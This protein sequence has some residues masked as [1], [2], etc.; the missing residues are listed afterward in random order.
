MKR[1]LAAAVLTAT[2]LIGGQ[3]WAQAAC[4]TAACYYMRAKSYYH[5]GR[6]DRAIQDL[7]EAIHLKPDYAE[8][9]VGR[10]YLFDKK[11][12]KDRAIQDYSEA[13]RLKPDYAMAYNNRGNI[14]ERTGQY[15]RAIQDFN[16]AIRLKPDYASAYNGLAWLLSATSNP[17]YLDG[18]EGVALALKA[19]SLNETANYVD[20]LGAAYVENRQFAK[21]VETYE[22]AMRLDAKYVKTYQEYLKKKGYY[23]GAIDGQ[24]GPGTREA[25]VACVNAG[26]KMSRIK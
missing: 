6:Y 15:D 7:T 19:V 12:Q 4:D 25:L 13:I 22:R 23:N 18:K 9:Y 17:Q 3:T 20:T 8:A 16:E 1:I 10:G 11:G 21:A 24:Y 14:Y 5:E 26:C 2:M